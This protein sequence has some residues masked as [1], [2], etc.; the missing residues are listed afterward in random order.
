MKCKY[1]SCTDTKACHVTRIM[2]PDNSERYIPCHWVVPGV[3]SNPYCMEKHIKKTIQIP[4]RG[5][6]I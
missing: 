3:C 2:N 4:K 6:K 5:N 1:C